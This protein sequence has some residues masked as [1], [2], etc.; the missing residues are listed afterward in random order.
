V[1]LQ[2]DHGALPGHAEVLLRRLDTLDGLSAPETATLYYQHTQY[3]ERCRVLGD[4]LRGILDLSARYW[5]AAALAGTRTALEHHLIDRL[6][7]LA[8]RWV[9]EIPVKAENVQTEEAR[10]AAL[11]AGMRLDFVSWRYRKVQGIIDLVIRH[12]AP[13]SPYYFW[14][15]QYN[16]F[17]VKKK[18][19]SRVAMGFRDPDVEQKS[20]KKSRDEWDRRFTIGSL[21]KNLEANRLLRGRVGVQ[22]DVHYA[23][24]SAF[25]HSV[26]QAY[27]RVHHRNT[28]IGTFDHYASELVLLYVVALAAAELEIFGRM[29]KRDPRLQLLEWATV[30]AEITAAREASSYF[31]FLSGEPHM[32]D[33]IQQVHSRKPI[34]VGGLPS[35]RLRV[36]PASLSPSRVRYYTDPLERIINMHRS[37][38]EMFSGQMF[39]SP[40]ERPNAWLR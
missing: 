25:V 30:Q 1:T 19:A 24:L 14:V 29:A 2:D 6:L 26:Q 34:L 35:K 7:F 16:P 20:A 4:H 32:Y 38:R 5:Y 13:V 22:V 27:D 12:S 11:K 8:D 9:A 23:F 36:N 18:V 17:R 28:P 21:Q 33:R 39:Q 37:S 3:A 10:L 40:F 31:W 15:Y